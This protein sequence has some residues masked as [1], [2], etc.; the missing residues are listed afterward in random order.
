MWHLT[1]QLDSFC[2]HPHNPSPHLQECPSPPPGTSSPLLLGRLVLLHKE[3]GERHQTYREVYRHCRVTASNW[4]ACQGERYGLERR[5]KAA[6]A[7]PQKPCKS[8]PCQE[9]LELGLSAADGRIHKHEPLRAHRFPIKRMG[10][11]T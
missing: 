3:R 2:V 7:N 10:N 4:P 9:L 5:E 1:E 6:P 11:A 8:S